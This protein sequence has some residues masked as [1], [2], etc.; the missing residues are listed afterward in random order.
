MRRSDFQCT[1]EAYSTASHPKPATVLV[2]LRGLLGKETFL[3][4]G[5]EFFDR[6][7]FE[8]PYLWDLWNTREDVSGRDLDWSWRSWYCET[9]LLDQAIVSVYALGYSAVTTLEDPGNLPMPARL[10]ITLAD[11]TVLRREVPVE[12]WLGGARSSRAQVPSTRVQR[13]EIDAEELFP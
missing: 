7:A 3:R 2:A 13:V 10:T 12:L 11:G 8:P 1:N 5:R 6:W 9:W 4:A